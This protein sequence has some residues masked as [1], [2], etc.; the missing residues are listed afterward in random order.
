MA[1]VVA[2]IWPSEICDTTARAVVLDV[3]ATEVLTLGLVMALDVVV[4][5]AALELDGAGV[6]VVRTAWEVETVAP[7]LESRRDEEEVRTGAG[8]AGAEL[9]EAA[10]EEVDVE[11]ETLE[12]EI[13]V[14][15][16]E[17]V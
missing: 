6:D 12:M 14:A 9:V 8:A 4:D 5:A 7:T 2:W 3:V 1:A 15:T 13:V 16:V 10:D 17:L 11:E